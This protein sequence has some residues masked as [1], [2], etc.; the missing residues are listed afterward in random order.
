MTG[1]A[2]LSEPLM[3][4]RWTMALNGVQALKLFAAISVTPK[5]TV[6]MRAYPAENKP[7]ATESGSGGGWF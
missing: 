1:V 3:T 2:R 5:K 7:L 4:L 6:E